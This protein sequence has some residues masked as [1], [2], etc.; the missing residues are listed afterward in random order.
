MS[1]NNTIYIYP[2]RGNG[3]TALMR[4]LIKTYREAG[5]EVKVVEPKLTSSRSIT[6]RS[7][8]IDKDILTLPQCERAERMLEEILKGGTK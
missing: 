4:E 6:L 8:L 1:D 7:L 5:Y 2:S 3:K